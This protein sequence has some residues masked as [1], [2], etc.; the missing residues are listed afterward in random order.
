MFNYFYL[1]ELDKVKTKT[2]SLVQGTSTRSKSASQVIAKRP[3]LEPL[4]PK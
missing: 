3:S 4:I 1:A 2:R